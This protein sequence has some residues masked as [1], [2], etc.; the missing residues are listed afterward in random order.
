M[1][2]VNG[3]ANSYLRVIGRILGAAAAT[4]LPFA[5]GGDEV[6]FVPGRRDALCVRPKASSDAYGKFP[7]V[8]PV[9]LDD[10]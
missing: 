6:H 5:V 8:L 9:A 7:C 4:L 10:L 3:G 2:C 1:E